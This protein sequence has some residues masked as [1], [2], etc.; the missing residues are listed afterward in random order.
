M[1][2]PNGH[3]MLDEEAASAAEERY[4]VLEAELQ[5]MR[6]RNEELARGM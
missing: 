5:A 6:Q 1:A 2:N 4:A 3:V